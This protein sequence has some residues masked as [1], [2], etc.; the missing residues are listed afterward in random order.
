MRKDWA[1]GAITLLLALGLS[2]TAPA[3]S[4]VAFS[5]DRLVDTAKVIVHGTVLSSETALLHGRVVTESTLEVHEV[6]KGDAA[7]PVLHVV[8]PGGQIPGRR[9]HVAGVPRFRQGEQ[10]C[11]FLEPSSMGWLLT[12]ASQGK[13]RLER[14]PATGLV[15]ARRSQ[16]GRRVALPAPGQTRRQAMQGAAPAEA[17]W[18]AFRQRILARV[19]G[20]R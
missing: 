7:D 2:S 15:T 20:G 13:Y 18:D 8:T 1:G 9:V 10:V 5:E 14:D 3:T 4:I 6:L 16:Q 17:D 19:R 12:G 11:V